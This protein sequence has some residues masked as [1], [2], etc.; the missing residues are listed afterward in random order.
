MGMPTGLSKSVSTS[1]RVIDW[2]ALAVG[3]IALVSAFVVSSTRVGESLTF[4][5]AAFIIFFALLALLVRNRRPDHWGLVVIGLTMFMVPWLGSGYSA[6][7]GAAWTC[8]VAG[9]LAMIL[10]GIGW[11]GD[12]P[13][14]EYGINE[15]SASDTRPSA[16]AVWIS[17]AA[18]ILGL[19]TIAL[20]ATLRSH[21]AGVAVMIGFGAM[22]AVIAVWSFLAANPTRDYLTLAVVGF[23]LFLAPWVGGFSGDNAAWTAWASGI[24]ATALGVVG[25][26]RGESLDYNTTVRENADARYRERY[27]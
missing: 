3:V 21:P 2:A 19:L 25:Y 8:W 16:I 26:L 14:T 6:D 1:A 13:P 9:S 4:G 24:S 23:A 5:F 12:K 18:L 22:I 7:P 20:G 11:L 27:R 15:T 10:G 17:R